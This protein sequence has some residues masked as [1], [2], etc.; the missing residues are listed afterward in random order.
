ME[1]STDSNASHLSDFGSRLTS[2]RREIF[3]CYHW[4]KV[5]IYQDTPM[6]RTRRFLSSALAGGLLLSAGL[7]SAETFRWASTTDPQTMDPH[8]VNS[9]PVLSFLNNVYEGLV[10]RDRNMSIEGSL[11]E[12]WTPLEDE[13]GWRFS[14]RQGVT[15]ADGAAFTAEDVLFSYERGSAEGS[16]VRSWFAPV[17]EVRV[18]SATT[19]A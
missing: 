3:W 6:A 4:T 14:L 13:P 7:A 10:R 16:D 18:G 5:A 12:S 15:F 2:P 8:A 19:R 9:A 17:R 11:A 1:P